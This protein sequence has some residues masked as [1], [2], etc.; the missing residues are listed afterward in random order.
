MGKPRKPLR[1]GRRLVPKK[2]TSML[3]DDRIEYVDWKDVDLLRKFVSDRAKIRSS[4]VTGATVQQQRDVAL[5]VK[6]A[7]EMALLPYA[8]KVTT[9]RKGRQGR[10]D[11]GDGY[12]SKSRAPRE[13][14]RDA[15]FESAPASDEVVV[16]AVTA[17]EE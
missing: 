6:N 9:Q 1:D 12:G 3:D 11:D 4:R 17:T 16:D 7:R 14:S 5:A 8:T 13:S 2:K 15:E 10:K